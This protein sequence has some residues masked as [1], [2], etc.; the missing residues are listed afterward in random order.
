MPNVWAIGDVSNRVPLTPAARMEGT[1][2]AN[3]LFGCVVFHLLTLCDAPAARRAHEGHRARQRP[4]R[5]CCLL[6]LA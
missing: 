6:R 3:A 5:V 2:L 1:A 4:L